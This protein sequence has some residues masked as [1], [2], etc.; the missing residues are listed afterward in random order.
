MPA[1]PHLHR[2]APRRA[3]WRAVLAGWVAL[4]IL[5]IG[6]AARSPQV[7][8]HI[9]CDHAEDAA[10]VCA[11]TLAAAG[12]CDTAA[13]APDL[14]PIGGAFAAIATRGA[15][16]AWAAPDYWLIPTHAPPAAA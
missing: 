9:H 8:D 5:G 7:H 6:L 13:S 14:A 3:A 4:A 16:F 11:I 12:F 15:S 10:H 2:F 1:L